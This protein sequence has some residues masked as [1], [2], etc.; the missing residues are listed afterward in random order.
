MSVVCV[1]VLPAL[2][3]L[4]GL[5]SLRYALPCIFTLV[6]HP[7]YS[8]SY[9]NANTLCYTW[10]HRASPLPDLGIHGCEVC[11]AGAHSSHCSCNPCPLWKQFC[12]CSTNW[13]WW[14]TTNDGS[15]PKPKMLQKQRTKKTTVWSSGSNLTLHSSYFEVNTHKVWYG[16]QNV[17]ADQI[18]PWTLLLLAMIN[19]RGCAVVEHHKRSIEE[20]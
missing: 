7:I 5:V 4:A 12:G 8:K 20:S 1:L 17:N 15:S 14:N 18:I 11:G 16:T 10:C 19:F 2:D 9:V 6:F 13:D 3:S